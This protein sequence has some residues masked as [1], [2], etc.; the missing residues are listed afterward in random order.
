[1]IDELKKF[2]QKGCGK[3]VF[4]ETFKKIR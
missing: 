3:V 4:I 1:M 2:E